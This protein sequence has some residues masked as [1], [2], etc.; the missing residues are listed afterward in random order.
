VICPT[1]VSV[2]PVSG[3]LQKYLET[4]RV[5][6]P[7]V[8]TIPKGSYVPEFVPRKVET[9]GV[10]MAPQ[11]AERP[12]VA[13][14]QPQTVRRFWLLL[15]VLFL[16]VI[17]PTVALTRYVIKND[18]SANIVSPGGAVCDFWGQFFDKPDEE[19]RIVYADTNFGL[20]QDMSGKTLNLGDYLS[21]KYLEDQGDKLREVATR[22]A[23]SPAD[24]SV[25]VHLATLAG[26][27]GG[28]ASVQFAR[29]A[30]AD[31]FRR[32]NTV[33][34]GSHRS[35]PWVEVYEPNLNFELKQNLDSG[36]PLFINHAPQSNEAATYAIPE[37][38]DTKGD[39]QKEFTS[40]GL[41][42]LLKICG[43]QGLIVLDKGLNMQATQ[44][45]GD[46]ITD[47]QRLDVL[48]HDIGHKP[49]TDVPPFESLIRITSLPGGYDSPK[50]IAYR[51]QPAESC[52]SR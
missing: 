24:L 41:V 38:L 31:Y 52:V 4:E 6:E 50:V 42:A 35:N 51:L 36:A 28:R 47:P 9:V 15:T 5:E 29:N 23:T 34:I 3:L 13:T 11:E 39:E 7:I 12:T 37:M 25:S 26:E 19:L 48:L 46:Q 44:A 40:Y 30:N 2:E 32:G 1:V 20:W 8:I 21:Y 10:P 43:E 33:L 16:I 27:F 14:P 17:F 45:A 18:R 22:R 49:G